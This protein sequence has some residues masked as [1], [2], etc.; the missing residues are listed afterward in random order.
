MTTSNN[1]RDPG[2]LADEVI[3]EEEPL[4]KEE[5][6]P[7]ASPEDLQEQ[8]IVAVPGEEEDEPPHLTG[9]VNEWD[10]V[11]QARVVEFD[12]DYR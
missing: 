9:E 11:E 10:A 8:I 12:E 1:H 5:R 4:T 7:E 3:E 6:D 2:I